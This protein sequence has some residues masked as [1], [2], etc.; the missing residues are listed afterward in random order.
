MPSDY[1]IYRPGRIRDGVEE[2]PITNF[3]EPKFIIVGQGV[4][5]L[6]FQDNCHGFIIVDHELASEHKIEFN[7]IFGNVHFIREPKKIYKIKSASVYLQ[8]D[9]QKL[10]S[11]ATVLE[12]TLDAGLDRGFDGYDEFIKWSLNPVENRSV[13]STFVHE[14]IKL[15]TIL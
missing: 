11:D 2:N 1:Y 13:I 10:K 8:K 5:E 3:E 7:G 4:T 15:C 14:V 6:K 12:V 9:F